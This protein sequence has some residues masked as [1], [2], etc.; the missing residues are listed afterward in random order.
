MNILCIRQIKICCGLW[1]FLISVG[2]DHLARGIKSDFP[3]TISDQC[4][5]FRSLC[6]L[7]T[8]TGII[9]TRLRTFSLKFSKVGKNFSFILIF[10]HAEHCSGQAEGAAW[11]R[12]PWTPRHGI[13]HTYALPPARACSFCAERT[14]FQGCGSGSVSMTALT[15]VGLVHTGF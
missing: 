3:K 6:M 13:H 10:P 11:E 12:G 14:V 5:D 7:C 8:E 9:R 15:D 1:V 4:A 2:S